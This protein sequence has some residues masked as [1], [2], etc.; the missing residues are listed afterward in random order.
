MLGS[1]LKAYKLIE[2]NVGTT[3]ELFVWLQTACKRGW[4][5]IRPRLVGT[6]CG[7]L[8][9]Q[10]TLCVQQLRPLGQGVGVG[11]SLVCAHVQRTHRSGIYPVYQ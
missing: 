11:H 5:S 2:I 6:Q 1:I 8:A 9:R 7:L 3:I 4:N 10:K